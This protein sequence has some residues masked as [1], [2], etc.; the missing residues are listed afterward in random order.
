MTTMV[1]LAA[2][3]FTFTAEQGR[4]YKHL[5]NVAYVCLGPK[6]KRWHTRPDCKGLNKC[7]STIEKV[8]IRY[9]EGTLGKTPCKICAR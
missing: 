1:M 8:T 4:T 6:A 2:V 7:S 3:A 9:A 5:T